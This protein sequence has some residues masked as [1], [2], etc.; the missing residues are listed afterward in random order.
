MRENQG[1]SVQRVADMVKGMSVAGA[2][3]FITMNGYEVRNGVGLLTQDYH[4]NRVNIVE[5]H[6]VIV[7][8]FIG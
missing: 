8:T 1:L 3:H 4:P 5:D 7:N 2:Q 6:G